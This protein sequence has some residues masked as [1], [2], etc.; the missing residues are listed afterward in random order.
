MQR[1]MS[2]RTPARYWGVCA[3]ITVSLAGCAVRS[4]PAPVAQRVLVSFWEHGEHSRAAYGVDLDGRARADESWRCDDVPDDVRWDGAMGIDNAYSSLLSLV[5][6]DDALGGVEPG[7]TSAAAAQLRSGGSLL[8]FDIERTE[9]PES[10]PVVVVTLVSLEARGPLATDTVGRLLGAAAFTARPLERAMAEYH[11]GRWRVRFSTLA[12]PLGPVLGTHP[13]H[14]VVVEFRIDRDG[15]AFAADVGGAASIET[16]IEVGAMLLSEW[17]EGVVRSLGLPD[18][19]PNDDGS[20]CA[21]MSVG[22][23]IELVPIAW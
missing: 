21:A 14:D 19:E 1:L 7:I 15:H 23:G 12:L 13:L 22:V 20:E 11:G 16:V 2:E 18:L 10:E 9:A 8:G 5:R 6:D 17:N 4:P 3:A